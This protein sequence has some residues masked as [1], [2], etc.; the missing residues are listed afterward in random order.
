MRP[1]VVPARR[2]GLLDRRE[3]GVPPRRALVH[4][5]VVS[6]R[7]VDP[8]VRTLVTAWFVLDPVVPDSNTIM[9][10]NNRASAIGGEAEGL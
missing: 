8:E 4:T 10:N 6:G 5:R 2:A 3:L 9:S 7:T 1:Q